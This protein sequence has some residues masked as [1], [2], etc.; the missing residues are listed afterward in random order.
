MAADLRLCGTHF[1]VRH[2]L[3][4]QAMYARAFEKKVLVLVLESRASE[5]KVLVLESRAEKKVLVLESGGKR[6]L[7]LKSG[8]QRL[9]RKF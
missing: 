4:S 2:S 1:L 5:K 6:V 8:A 3:L 7:V 9:R